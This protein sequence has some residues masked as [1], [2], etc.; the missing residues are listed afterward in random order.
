M[1]CVRIGK[2]GRDLCAAAGAVRLSTTFPPTCRW[3]APPLDPNLDA[4]FDDAVAEQDD[5]LIGFSFSGG[6]TRAAAFS[7]GVLEELGSIP[8]RAADPTPCWSASTFLSGVSGGSVTAAYYGLKKR[9]ALSDFRER[10]LLQDAEAGLTTQLSLGTIGRALAAASMTPRA[11]PVGSTP[12]CSRMRLSAACRNSG[13]PRVWINASD[14][15]NRVPFVFDNTAFAAICSDLS[16][17]PLSGRRGCVCRGAARLCAG[18]GAGL[19]R[20][21]QRA[22][23]AVGSRAQPPNRNASPMLSAYSKAVMRYRDGA[24]PYIKLM[25]GGL[26]D[27]YGVLR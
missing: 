11:S 23:A 12:T 25:D 22:A 2:R 24:V 1:R 8:M 21:M 16:K 14:I 7:F 4:V 27:N 5:L 15:C 19:P 13:S 6:G 10:F 26:V 3:P 17:Y 20:H 9:A 18:R